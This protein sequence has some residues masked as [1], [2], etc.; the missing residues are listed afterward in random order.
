MFPA[1]QMRAEGFTGTRGDPAAWS[2]RPAARSSPRDGWAGSRA[3]LCQRSAVLPQ[4]QQVV[5]WQAR[6]GASLSCNGYTRQGAM[7]QAGA[8][9]LQL[10]ERAGSYVRYSQATGEMPPDGAPPADALADV[11]LESFSGAAC[12]ARS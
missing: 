5:A 4:R 2:S 12:S 10:P 6:E 9:G 1:R 7:Y 11:R 3:I 8:S